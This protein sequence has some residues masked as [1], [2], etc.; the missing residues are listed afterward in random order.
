MHTRTIFNCILLLFA[1]GLAACGDS[2]PQTTAGPREKTT[3]APDGMAV[4]RKNCVACHGAAGN[5]GLNGSKDL[6]MSILPL[7][8]RINIITNGKKMMTPFG[9]VLTP[10]EI[11]AVAIYT[12]TLNHSLND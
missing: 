5:L 8:E 7:E 1:L 3:F 12:R 6:T 2:E 10:E 11:S 4:F 9:K